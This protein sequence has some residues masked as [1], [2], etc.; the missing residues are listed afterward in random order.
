MWGF[1]VLFFAF[2]ELANVLHVICDLLLRKKKMNGC[3]VTTTFS[4]THAQCFSNKKS[5]FHYYAVSCHWMN[6]M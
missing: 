6:T 5:P 1:F 4:V 2:A 3:L